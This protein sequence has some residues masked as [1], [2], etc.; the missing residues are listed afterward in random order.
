MITVG[1]LKAILKNMDD[2]RLVV[3]AAD[4][5]GNAFLP[6]QQVERCLYDLKEGEVAGESL[7]Q[8]ATDLR[9]AILLWPGHP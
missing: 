5:E 8:P 3:V 7:G 9:P 6:L 2:H 4:E 1:E